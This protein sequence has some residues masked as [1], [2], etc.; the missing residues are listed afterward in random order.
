M[1]QT[2][3]FID[4]MEFEHHRKL[5]QYLV[6]EQVAVLF[7]DWC[8]IYDHPIMGDSEYSHYIAQLQ[9]HGLLKGDDLTDRFFHILTVIL[10]PSIIL[11]SMIK[12]RPNTLNDPGTCCHTHCCL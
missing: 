11:V 9:Q 5:M 1:L 3:F 10:I 2:F 8:H 7:S 4:F 12:L 6:D